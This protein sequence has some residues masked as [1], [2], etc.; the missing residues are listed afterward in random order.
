M[1]KAFTIGAP[2]N[3]GVIFAKDIKA[4]YAYADNNKLDMMYGD[5][6]HIIPLDDFMIDVALHGNGLYAV[7]HA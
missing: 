3:Y 7:Y 1:N 2:D 4:A 6:F 5:D